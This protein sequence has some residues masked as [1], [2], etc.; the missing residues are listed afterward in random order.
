MTLTNLTFGD[1]TNKALLCSMKEFMTA[2][3]AQLDSQ[4]EDV[5]QVTSSVLRNL[6]WNADSS[7]R[8]ALRESNAVSHLT[9]AA[10][11]SSKESTLKAALSA[12][13]NLSSHSAS[14]KVSALINY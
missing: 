2:L 3:V 13:W 14:N 10:I 11:K 8:V 4:N 9:A 7:S 6:S 12:L 1:G 5:R